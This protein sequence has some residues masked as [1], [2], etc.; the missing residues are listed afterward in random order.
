MS[1]SVRCFCSRRRF[2]QVDDNKPD[3]LDPSSV[4]TVGKI[5]TTVKVLAATVVALGVL[6]AAWAA[7]GL[8]VPATKRFVNGHVVQL[9]S[10]QADASSRIDDLA[11]F[12]KQTRGIIL[13]QAR[14]TS[15]RKSTATRKTQ[16][17][18]KPRD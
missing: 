1:Q 12:A 13:R 7:I 17:C 8:P 6:G 11:K 15:R 10:S 9:V 4:I 16:R 14:G 2:N 3:A 5:V 18:R